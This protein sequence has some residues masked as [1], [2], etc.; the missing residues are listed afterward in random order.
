MGGVTDGK[1]LTFGGVDVQLPIVG[2]FSANLFWL[3]RGLVFIFCILA[4]V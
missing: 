2:R 3:I 4:A 1:V